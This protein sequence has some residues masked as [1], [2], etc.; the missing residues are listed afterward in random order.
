[1]KTADES[2]STLK[3][4]DGDRRFVSGLLLGIVAVSIAL[5]LLSLKSAIDSAQLPETKAKRFFFVPSQYKV[6]SFREVQ[7]GAAIEFESERKL[8]PSDTASEFFAMQPRAALMSLKKGALKFVESSEE[9]TL[10]VEY[11]LRRKL[12]RAEFRRK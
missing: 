9:R 7:G 5:I 4:T 6:V 1:M 3:T 8:T 12:Y 10:T 2:L 11:D